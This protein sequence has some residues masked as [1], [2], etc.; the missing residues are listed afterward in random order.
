VAAYQ[1]LTL[2]PLSPEIGDMMDVLHGILTT[3]AFQDFSYVA[4]LHTCLWDVDILLG[5][6][7]ILHLVI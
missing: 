4:E 6:F 7:C 2:Y 5:I 1:S 3:G